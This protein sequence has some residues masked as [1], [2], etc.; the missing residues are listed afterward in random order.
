MLQEAEPALAAELNELVAVIGGGLYSSAIRTAF[1]IID[2]LLYRREFPRYSHYVRALVPSLDEVPVTGMR[3]ALV[4][5]CLAPCYVNHD[6]SQPNPPAALNRHAVMHGVDR[7]HATFR[8]A[9]FACLLAA[10]LL[11]CETAAMSAH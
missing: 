9:L 7:Q 10:T 3:D 4:R 6:V 8:D 5:H 11:E 1:A 2:A